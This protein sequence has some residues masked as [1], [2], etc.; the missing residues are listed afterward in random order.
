MMR[1]S[2]G[3]APGSKVFG[4]EK[5]TKRRDEEAK[6]STFAMGRLVIGMILGPKP[7][8]NVYKYGGRS[9]TG[10]IQAA[11]RQAG[12]AIWIALRLSETGRTG[13]DGLTYIQYLQ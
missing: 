12:R 13:P 4:S 6:R 9:S 2:W 5:N 11:S 1:L 3:Y 7:L 10:E 8:V